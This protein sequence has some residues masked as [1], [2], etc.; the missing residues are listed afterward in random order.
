MGECFYNFVIRN[1][2]LS[3][4]IMLYVFYIKF[5]IDKDGQI[6]KNFKIFE[7]EMYYK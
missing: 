5:Y 1:I 3:K 6:R 7:N 4:N 2:F